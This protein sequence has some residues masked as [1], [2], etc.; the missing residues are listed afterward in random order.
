[1]VFC[2]NC[3]TDVPPKVCERWLI[4]ILETYDT[5]RL[6]G[7]LETTLKHRSGFGKYLSINSEIDIS[8]PS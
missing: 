3:R 2:Q 8:L 4:I 5:F 7:P 1:M 6:S